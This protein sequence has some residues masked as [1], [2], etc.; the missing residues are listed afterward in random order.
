MR[1]SLNF[2]QHFARYE[3]L[4]LLS[5]LCL[6]SSCDRREEGHSDNGGPLG[7]EDLD[8]SYPDIRSE[9]ETQIGLTFPKDCIWVGC[10]SMSMHEQAYAIGFRAPKGEVENMFSPLK[11]EWSTS[12]QNVTFQA[13]WVKWLRP[14]LI[15]TF[16]SCITNYPIEGSDYLQVV[17]DNSVER[18]E[19][20]TV[21]IVWS[22]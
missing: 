6:I 3:R 20:T 13:E 18:D 10:T 4:V 8:M 17:Y 5:I 1:S 16:R 11:C 9:I 7:V 12:Q 15:K 14:D 19:E 2:V 21:Y 22:R